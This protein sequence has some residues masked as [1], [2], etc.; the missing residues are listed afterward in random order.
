MTN[1]VIAN[2]KE[3]EIPILVKTLNSLSDFFKRYKEK[4]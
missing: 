1:A 4:E 2:L 3:D